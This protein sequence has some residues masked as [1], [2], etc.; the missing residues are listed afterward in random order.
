MAG[1]MISIIGYGISVAALVAL[2]A[3]AAIYTNEKRK[4]M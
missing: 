3:G 2:I 4:K 1:E